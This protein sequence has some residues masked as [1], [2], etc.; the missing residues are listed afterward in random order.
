M[1]GASY[2]EAYIAMFAALVAKAIAG[3][4]QKGAAGVHGME[5]GSRKA[6]ANECEEGQKDGELHVGDGVAE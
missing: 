3:E 5:S 6:E 4:D 1:L 2:L